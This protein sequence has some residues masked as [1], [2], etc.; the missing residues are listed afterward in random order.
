MTAVADDTDDGAAVAVAETDDAE[1]PAAATEADVPEAAAAAMAWANEF[2]DTAMPAVDAEN[3]APEAVATAMAWGFE[4][5][6]ATDAT[7]DLE[8]IPAFDMTSVADETDSGETSG[9]ETDDAEMDAAETAAAATEADVPG[10]AATV[11]AAEVG[12]ALNR[13]L[14][15]LYSTAP[16]SAQQPL[17]VRIE[18]TIVD[19]TNKLR[20]AE[21]ARP[22]GPWTDVSDE[23]TVTPRH[24]EFEPRNYAAPTAEEDVPAMTPS[25]S[26]WDVPAQ[27]SEADQVVAAATAPIA[28]AVPVDLP[29]AVPS[30]G[31][32]EEPPSDGVRAAVGPQWSNTDP[33]DD[34]NLEHAPEDPL[35]GLPAASLEPLA[36]TFVH[37]EPTRQDVYAHATA[38]QAAAGTVTADHSDLW[39]LASE[40]G[41]AVASTPA[42]ET[43]GQHPT[44]LTAGLTVAMAVL[45]ILLVLVFIQLMT[46]LLR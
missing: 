33:T 12:D 35:T 29:W 31:P 44:L 27:E 16:S 21:M 28:P 1:T 45:V 13:Q 6:R 24:F 14:P 5:A 40:P 4:M 22:V 20:S 46:S 10:S 42:V 34:V 19:E 41:E 9:S 43:G 8:S 37:A 3:N 30:Q 17:V 39:F 18:L 2:D 36:S 32:V 38:T 23:D 15:A 11:V 25:P 26:P 7:V